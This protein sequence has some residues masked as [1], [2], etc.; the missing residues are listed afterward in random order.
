[1]GECSLAQQLE[2]RIQAQNSYSLNRT[3]CS[4][5]GTIDLR[6]WCGSV[7]C[8]ASRPRPLRIRMGMYRTTCLLPWF[9]HD[10]A[11]RRKP[12]ILFALS[13][14]SV[15]VFPILS[16]E[17]HFHLRTLSFI[18][19]VSRIG[20]NQDLQRCSRMIGFVSAV[21]FVQQTMLVFSLVWPDL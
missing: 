2:D 9:T 16:F 3:R 10:E 12:F 7:Y 21:D 14:R 6:R 11:H 8:F 5:S 15:P 1:M 20:S 17:R 19:G 18:P 13:K 4:K